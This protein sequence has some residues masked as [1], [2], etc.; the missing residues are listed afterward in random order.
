MASTRKVKTKEVENGNKLVSIAT[1]EKFDTLNIRI[2]YKIN[3]K[4]N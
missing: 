2:E 4:D 3:F 1:A